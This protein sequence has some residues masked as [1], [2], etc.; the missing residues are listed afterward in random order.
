M[1]D[2]MTSIRQRIRRSGA[3]RFDT[4]ALAALW[5][6]YGE[7]ER[8]A[9][10]RVLASGRW[11]RLKDPDWSRGEA[12]LFEQDFAA[13]LGVD[14]ALA[15]STGTLA[16]E[17]GLLALG[18]RRGDEVIVQAGT[19]FG[20]VTP[21][22]R[23]GARPVFVDL[24]EDTL[25]IDPDAVAAAVTPATR[26]VIAVHLAGLPAD[27][28]RLTALC[29]RHGIGLLEDCAQAVGTT[30]R[31]RPV[32][33]IGDVG[34][35]SLQQEKMLQAG[36]GGV[37][38]CRDPAVADRAFAFHQGFSMPGSP[39]PDRHE[40]AANMRL[41]SFQAAIAG[42]QLTRLDEQIARRSATAELFASLLKPD[43]PVELTASHPGTT[44]WSP[45][46]LPL[47]LRPDRPAALTQRLLVDLLAD[48]G[49][50]VFE[51]HLEPVYQRPIFL[52]NEFD[53]RD[54]GCPVTERASREHL[55]VLQ[56]FLLSPPEWTHRLV[57]LLRDVRDAVRAE[58]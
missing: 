9:L 24:D 22:L 18:V 21:I 25:T 23:I 12:G 31:N 34:A 19:F 8:R 50:P 43:D 26:A 56:P 35:F 14:R 54:T 28:D 53:Y 58:S 20:S 40:L 51:G 47:R 15:V 46:S 42:A 2:L 11:S 10:E 32:G 5:P 4:D 6:V 39:V 48:E 38:V 7:P 27:L 36:E 52:D 13:H 44:R 17:L 55:V 41:S 49:L 3:P 16:I 57:E 37:I 33:T 29:D 45:Y 1:T 30:W